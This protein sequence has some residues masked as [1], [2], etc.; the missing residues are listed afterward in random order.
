VKSG[1]RGRQKI[2]N[3]RFKEETMRIAR[4]GLLLALLGVMAP[5]A[6]AQDKPRT[7][8]ASRQ[9]TPLKVTVVFSEYDGEKKV[10]SL[11]YTLFLKTTEN[12][13]SRGSVRMGVRVPI[14]AGG[15][16]DKIQYMDVGSNIDCE[17]ESP[18][19]GRYLLELSLERSSIYSG[20]GAPEATI[21]SQPVLRTFR[22]NLTL[23]MRDGQTTQSTM[24]TDPW[25]GHVLRVEVTLNVVK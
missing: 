14:S 11:P 18:E 6:S 10:S 7:A 2:E 16:D 21:A 25:N 1:S 19:E 12:R 20:P 24:A 15:K 17:A 9:V 4:T 23:M 3:D 22:A 8:E 13:S 5:H